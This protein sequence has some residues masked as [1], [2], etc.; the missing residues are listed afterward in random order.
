MYVYFDLSQ[1]LPHNVAMGNRI[2]NIV[3]LREHSLI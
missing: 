1:L 3:V 2:M